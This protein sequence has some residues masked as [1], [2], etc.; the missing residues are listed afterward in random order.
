MI[1]Q[2]M[3]D[4][5]REYVHTGSSEAFRLMVEAYGDAVYSQCRRQLRDSAAAEEVTQLVFITLAQRAGKV[6]ASA[7]L[8]GWLF[9]TTRYCCNN[10]QRGVS[11]RR[12]AEQKAARMRT[13]ANTDSGVDQVFQSEVEPILDDAIAR[14]GARDRDAVLLRFFEGRSVREV[15]MALGVSEDAAKQRISRAVEKL[16]AFFV[17]R[18]V[19]ADSGAVLSVL[20]EAVRPAQPGVVMTAAKVAMARL[21]A[22][23]AGTGGT[24][25]KSSRLT[26]TW[27]KVAAGLVM[28]GAVAAVIIS[29]GHGASAQTPVTPQVAPVVAAAAPVVTAPAKAVA[30]QDTPLHTLQTI[31]QGIETDNKSM[32]DACLCDD[33]NDPA[34]AGLGKVFVDG[35][36]SLYRIQKDCNEILNAPL[37]ISDLSF[38][39]VATT[40]GGIRGMLAVP[41]QL[42]VKIDGDI[43]QIRIS[44]PP[45]VF[46]GVG[47]DR[48][49]AMGRWSGA[50]IVMQ[51]VGG[52]WKLNTDRTFNFLIGISRL[53]GNRT[54]NVEVE[55]QVQQGIS[56]SM[57]SVAGQI[58]AG[59]ITTPSAAG[60]AVRTRVLRAFREAGVNGSTITVLPVIGG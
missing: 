43:A 37:Q 49:I 24:F 53:E 35:A 44:L 47:P 25:A 41:D 16:R 58:E 29:E 12:L 6:T 51:R 30:L 20:S 31:C 21:A 1:Q 10:Y 3:N 52:D 7:A 19:T 56:D 22:G 13:Q 2:T 8:S 17:S 54:D 55:R 18:G 50:M 4:P 14:L 42:Q 32:I 48:N 5:L 26:G 59:S 38:S 23:A 39:D 28:T 57:E 15:G 33:G 27:A 11:R 9:N 40:I 46:A 60:N 36:G 45:Q 34:L